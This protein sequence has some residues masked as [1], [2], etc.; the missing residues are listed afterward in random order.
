M[1]LRWL[2]S[3]SL[4]ECRPFFISTMLIISLTL[5]SADAR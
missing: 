3:S 5:L 4:E 1:V 2:L